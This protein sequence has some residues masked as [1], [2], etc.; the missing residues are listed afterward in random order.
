MLTLRKAVKF[1]K[2][3]FSFKLEGDC[4]IR[5]NV[6]LPVTYYIER[7]DD[8]DLCPFADQIKWWLYT[9]IGGTARKGDK[10]YTSASLL[11]S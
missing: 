1:I 10:D 5:R 6:H 3:A 8:L 9:E 11:G 7:Y 2:N 4:P